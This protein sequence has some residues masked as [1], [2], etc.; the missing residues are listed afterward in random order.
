MEAFQGARTLTGRLKQAPMIQPA[1]EMFNAAMKPVR[2]VK[3]RLDIKKE[4]VRASNKAAR[5][6]DTLMKE[7]TSRV[8][9]YL[10][11]FPEFSA[12]HPFEQSMLDL[13][14]GVANYKRILNTG[15][16]LRKAIIQVRAPLFPVGSCRAVVPCFGTHLNPRV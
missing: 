6:M 1:D 10:T 13:S 11:A 9:A 3:E 12:L 15:D 7:L 16:Q 5:A 2:Y 4:E 8:N 14:I